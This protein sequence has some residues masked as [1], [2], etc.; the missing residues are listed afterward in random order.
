MGPEEFSCGETETYSR[1]TC[2]LFV[3]LGLWPD[4]VA[5]TDARAHRHGHMQAWPNVP[6]RPGQPFGGY[7]SFSPT[8]S[9]SR[10]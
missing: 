2:T 3:V 4:V 5:A 6:V 8:V 7:G 1:L 9:V 10:I